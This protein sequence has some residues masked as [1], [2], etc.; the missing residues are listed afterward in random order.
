MRDDNGQGSFDKEYIFDCLFEN[1][2]DNFPNFHTYINNKSVDFEAFKEHF[3]NQTVPKK[4]IFG[5]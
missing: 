1:G 2:I 5:R 3:Q 4:G